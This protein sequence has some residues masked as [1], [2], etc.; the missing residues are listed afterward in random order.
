VVRARAESVTEALFTG[1]FDDAAMYPPA[2]TELTTAVRAHAAHRL[3][4]Y[5]DMVGP[6]VCNAVR[7]RALDDE[8]RTLGLP[9][10]DVAVVVADGLDALSEA[11][12][13]ADQCASLRLCAIEVP[14]GSHR[15][16]EALRLLTP[17]RERTTVYVEIPVLNVNERHVHELCAAGLRLKLRTGGTSIDTFRTEAELAAPILMCAAERLAFKCTA[18]LHNA[19]RHRD[20]QTLFEHHGFLN[21]A[22][23]A[24]IAAA[25]G[26]AAG[27]AAALAER[28]PRALAYKIDD[29]GDTD[30][31]AIRALFTSFGTCSIAEPIADLVQLGLVT[32]R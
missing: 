18:G 31:A 11:V 12:A 8:V 4:W 24:R 32:V 25:T 23:A 21:I 26:S 17:I 13:I 3:S 30:I 20:P 1:L 10:F 16:E 6:F 14:L 22:L 28:D 5:A 7:L 27:T 19:V 9:D 29:L 15:R 2:A